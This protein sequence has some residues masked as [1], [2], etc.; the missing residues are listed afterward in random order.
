MF[1][2]MNTGLASYLSRPLNLDCPESFLGLLFDQTYQRE[3]IPSPG[4]PGFLS[5][6]L[7]SRRCFDVTLRFLHVAIRKEA[8]IVISSDNPNNDNEFITWYSLRLAKY[9]E[10]AH[11]LGM[12]KLSHASV[13]SGCSGCPQPLRSP[14]CKRT[15]PS[16]TGKI[17]ECVS[18]IQANRVQAFLGVL[19]HRNPHRHDRYQ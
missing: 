10:R 19:T 18:D 11:F 9:Y 15:S 1:Q 14:T 8:Y 6:R 17:R 16:G 5:K 7:A 3:K 2:V 12:W 13:N 4:W